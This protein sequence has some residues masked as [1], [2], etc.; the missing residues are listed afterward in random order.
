[1]IFLETQENQT[2]SYLEKNCRHRHSMETWEKLR[3]LANELLKP[4]VDQLEKIL[5]LHSQVIPAGMKTQILRTLRWLSNFPMHYNFM[6][7]GGELIMGLD[8]EGEEPVITFEG[9]FQLL[10]I[11]DDQSRQVRDSTTIT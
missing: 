4:T 2:L 1:M 11:L 6:F 3:P 7:M 9:V 5:L 8:P 10:R